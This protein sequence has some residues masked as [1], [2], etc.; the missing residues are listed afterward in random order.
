[1]EVP[2]FMTLL[3]VMRTLPAELGLAELPWQNKLLGAL[4]VRI[5]HLLGFSVFTCD[6]RSSTTSTAPLLDH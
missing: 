2:G 4:F 1:M 5:Y 6:S 3:Y